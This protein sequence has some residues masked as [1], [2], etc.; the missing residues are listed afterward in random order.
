MSLVQ[1]NLLTNYIG[2]RWSGGVGDRATADRHGPKHSCF[3]SF[4]N[5]SV[6]S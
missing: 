6:Y 5:E 1:S 2:Y 3:Q 4:V